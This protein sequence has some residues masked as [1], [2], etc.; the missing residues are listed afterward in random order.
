MNSNDNIGLGVGATS[1]EEIIKVRKVAPNLPLL[2]PGVGAQGGS[3][4]HSIKEGTSS[5]TAL[6]N[7]SRAI[8]FACSM[9]KQDIHD[10]AKNYVDAMNRALL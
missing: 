8:S 1:F 2:I 5:G 3:L 7:I 10:A 4:E 6:I 9:T